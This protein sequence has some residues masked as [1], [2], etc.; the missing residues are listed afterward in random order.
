MNLHADRSQLSALDRDLDCS[1]HFR[2]PLLLLETT[3]MLVQSSGLTLRRLADLD[4]DRGLRPHHVVL[5][6]WHRHTGSRHPALV[7]GSQAHLIFGRVCRLRLLLLALHLMHQ[8]IV[9][10]LAFLLRDRLVVGLAVENRSAPVPD[11]QTGSLLVLFGL[12]RE[13]IASD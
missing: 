6:R 1:L 12:L 10:L 13:A 2:G 4:V 3:Q 9:T 11:Q 5:R 7:A 8:I